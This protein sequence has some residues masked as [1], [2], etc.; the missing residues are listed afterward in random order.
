MVAEQVNESYGKPCSTQLPFEQAALE[1]IGAQ[2]YSKRFNQRRSWL[3][4][5]GVAI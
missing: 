1:E 4:F 3:H 2:K 5:R